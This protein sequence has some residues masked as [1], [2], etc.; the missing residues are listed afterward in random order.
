MR[1]IN[2]EPVIRNMTWS[3]SRISAF[4]QCPYRWCLKYL[5]EAK[6]TPL[7]FSE[8]GKFVHELLADFYAD[9]KT[10]EEIYLTYLTQFRERVPPGAPNG[11]VFSRY[12]LDGAKFLSEIEKLKYRVIAV[13]QK[14]LFEIGGHSFVAFVDLL[15]E[16]VDGELV[17]IDNKSRNLKKRS[18]RSKRTNSDKELRSGNK[19]R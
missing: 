1:D 3:Y 10:G 15:C 4:D 16:N 2:Y 12:F 9:R 19:L 18:K 5:C 17:L 11:A 7:F 6:T 8:Y 13:E 14:M